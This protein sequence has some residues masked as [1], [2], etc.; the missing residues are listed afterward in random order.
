MITT[1]LSPY[2]VALLASLVSAVEW[3]PTGTGWFPP[4]GVSDTFDALVADLEATSTSRMCEDPLLKRLFP[5][6]NPTGT[7]AR[8]ISAVTERDLGSRRWPMLSGARPA[9]HH[10]SGTRDLLIPPEWGLAADPDQCPV[11][12]PP[13]WDLRRL[14]ADELK[15]A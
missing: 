7:T 3:S 9:R 10:S 4:A 11:A 12:W 1:Q 13:A 15:P 6:P 2:D 14:A 5:D 8:R